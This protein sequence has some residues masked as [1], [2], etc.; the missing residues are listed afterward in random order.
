MIPLLDN[1]RFNDVASSNAVLAALTWWAALFLIG[2]VAWPLGF[3]LFAELPDRGYALSRLL[4]WLALAVPLWWL[5]HWGLPIFTVAGVWWT[6]AVLTGAGLV[7]AVWQRRGIHR[8][9]RQGFA[10]LLYLEA[11]FTFAFVGGVLLRLANPDLWHP[12]FGGEKFMEMAIW[13][14]ILR[15]PALPPLDVHFA[16]ESLNYYYFGHFLLAVLTKFTGIW[17]EV[18]FNLAIPTLLG[19]AFLLSWA[20]VWY[21]HLRPRRNPIPGQTE[22]IE[23]QRDWTR[24][25]AKALWSPFLLLVIGNPQSGLLVVE[26]LRAA[27]GREEDIHRRPGFLGWDFS[28]APRSL[29]DWHMDLAD[30]NYWWEVSRVIPNAITEFP[31]WTFVFGD[32]HAH[33]LVVPLT[34]LL[35][36]LAVAAMGYLRSGAKA[37]VFLIL[38][39]VVCGLVPATNIWDLPLAISL[40]AIAILLVSYRLFFSRGLFVPVAL[41]A[42]TAGAGIAGAASVP[43]WS[44]FD[45][46]ASGGI[47]W[48]SQGDK[49][50]TWL[51]M[52]A[53]FY[54]LIVCWLLLEVVRPQANAQ[55]ETRIRLDNFPLMG[56]GA[57]LMGLA[58]SFQHATLGM[59]AVPWGLACVVLVRKWHW[60]PDRE[61]ALWCLLLLSVWAGSQVVVV[62]DFL[63]GSEYYRMNTVFKFFFQGWIL[64]S[65]VC[66]I[67]IPAIW[68]ELRIRCSPSTF[69]AATIVC[70]ALLVLSLGFSFVGVPARLAV[71][72]PART[73]EWGTLNGLAFMEVGRFMEPSGNFI[74]LSHD[75]EAID[76]IN[77]HVAANVTILESAQVD[78]YRS[79][80]TRIASLTGLPGLLGMHEQ[81]Q[82]PSGDVVAR[83]DLMHRLWNTPDKEKLLHALQDHGIG[84][85]YVGQLERIEHEAGAELYR[86]MAVAGR[87][88]ILFE[89]EKV[90]ILA[91]PET[92]RAILTG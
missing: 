67:L 27:F 68:R 74:D 25:M 73:P 92:A 72:F 80:G 39:G 33:L 15:S 46:V 69:L 18:A 23:S 42:L 53:L 75:R 87:L 1:F 43:F 21:Y 83:K 17:T 14:G 84:L 34:L 76:W 52:W 36:C 45:L 24:G 89:N 40:V 47:G 16:G 19:L 58:V 65:L 81:E 56:G 32:L 20:G 70:A 31:A 13:N 22:G 82:R 66:A 12:W 11:G 61:V 8:Y 62:K 49:P 7:A 55:P 28:D 57:L 2:L 78:Y 5:A 38:A 91:L 4:G 3:R 48:V 88:A 77:A 85:I 10:R 44:N 79:G 9:L 6:C 35:F 90:L 30:M 54:F 51:R 71:R 41:T 59:I 64:A 50:E 37:V 26:K 86:D 63:F 29:Q 60:E